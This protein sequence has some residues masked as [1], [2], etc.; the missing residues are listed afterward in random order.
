[1]FESFVLSVSTSILCRWYVGYMCAC[2]WFVCV[3]YCLF[4]VGLFVVCVFDGCCV[5]NLF[6]GAVGAMDSVSDFESGGCGFE[7]RIAYSFAKNSTT[8]TPTST[9]F[10]ASASRPM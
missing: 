5:S 9:F 3:L 4:R 1:V 6:G 7:S 2:V 10:L 8:H